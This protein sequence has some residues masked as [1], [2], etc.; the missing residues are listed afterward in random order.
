MPVKLNTKSAQAYMLDVLKKFKTDLENRLNLEIPNQDLKTAVD[1][2]NRIRQTVNRIY[3]I[4]QK[5]PGIIQGGNLYAVVKAAMIMDR[6]EFL[7][8]LTELVQDIE[9][10]AGISNQTG[11]E[12]FNS[13]KRLVLTG[14][15][16]NT[17][18]IH[19]IIENAGGTVVYDDLCIGTRYFGSHIDTQA[20]DIMDGIAEHY[21]QR[22]VCPAKHSGTKSR[23]ESLIKIARQSRANGV[24]FIILKFCDPHSFDYPYITRILKQEKIPCMI[25][26]MEKHFS[27]DGQFKTRCEAFIEM[28]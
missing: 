1:V 15:I 26:E 17:P 3:E 19:T 6:F 8:L 13:T 2:C 22:I 21:L 5:H 27:L 18:D 20:G 9:N 23:V 16:C 7:E 4:R 11:P 14:C 28:L 25:L 24:I 12:L 10:K